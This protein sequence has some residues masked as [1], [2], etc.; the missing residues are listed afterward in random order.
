MAVSKASDERARPA[1][2]LIASLTGRQRRGLAE[3]SVGFTDSPACRLTF[4][5]LENGVPPSFARLAETQ[6]LTRD[7]IRTIIPDRTL[8]RR[9]ATNEPFKLEEADGIARLLRVVAM[10]RQV[11]GD[12]ALADEWLRSANPALSNHIP[13]RMA[14]SDLG[15]REV[16]AALGRLEHGVFG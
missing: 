12:S 16:E 5:D 14:R 8:E 1:E 3:Q 2:S 6:G 4:L 11:F 9:I 15:G 7:D 13:I 10:A